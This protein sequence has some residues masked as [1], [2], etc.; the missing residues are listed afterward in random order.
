MQKFVLF[1]YA[2]YCFVSIAFAQQQEQQRI[3]TLTECIDYALEQNIQIQKYTLSNEILAE[4]LLQA[5]AARLPSLNAS[6]SQQFSSSKTY[7]PSTDIFDNYVGSSGTS[8]GLQSSLTL[9]N[10]FKIENIIKYRSLLAQNGQYFLEYTK[11]NIRLQ[12]LHAYISV[13]FA[14]EQVNNARIRI[15]STQ[16]L[17]K[18]TETRVQLGAV[19]RLDY[20]QVKSQLASEKS[21]LTNAEN[22]Y[23]IAVLQLQQIMQLPQEQT[24][25]IKQDYDIDSFL[26]FS[27]VS[28]S[29]LYQN[30]IQ[31]KPIVKHA[32]LQEEASMLSQKIA[33]AEY[34][35]QL[36]LRGSLSTS[37]NN[38]FYDLEFGNQIQ[39]RITP[40]LGISLSIPIYANRSI[41]TSVKIAEIQTK[42]AQLETLD[43]KN[44]LLK[45]IE[46]AYADY[47]SAFKQYEAAIEE[48]EAVEEAYQLATEKFNIGLLDPTQYFIQQTQATIAQNTM[49]QAKFSVV[50]YTKIVDYYAG[51]PISL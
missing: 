17:L 41:T 29:K 40:S 23:T 25:T 33:R 49:L 51:I 35:P 20:L 6:A 42:S 15:E 34:L 16:E 39:N 18:E 26:T 24:L 50:L 9:F 36:S 27:E 48:Y 5:K 37:Y 10:G 1:I 8:L 3:W 46:Q 45:A 19:S 22:N 44:T 14:H 7:V 31:T 43:T 4:Q 28:V 38:S 47:T 2:F 30:S 21:T 13:L 12:V 11:D 32:L